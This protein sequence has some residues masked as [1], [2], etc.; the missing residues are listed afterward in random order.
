MRAAEWINF[1]FFLFLFVLAWQRPLAPDRRIKITA[2]GV[3][4][5]GLVSGV[6]FLDRFLSP[7]PASVIRDWLPA[8]LFLVAYW[9]AGLFFTTPS[10]KLQ[11]RLIR[12]DRKVLGPLKEY[13]AVASVRPW[14]ASYFELAY[15]LC[16]SLVPFGIGALYIARMGRYADEFWTIVLPS[17]YL[18]YT[19]LPFAQTLPPRT[20]TTGEE[21]ILPPTKV[22]ELNLWILHHGSIQ[23]NTFPSAHVATAFS[24]SLALL[25]LLPQAGIAFLWISVSI[26]IGAVLGR[27]HYAADVLI[28]AA[29]AIAIFLILTIWL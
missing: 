26:A 15:L 2:V 14:I 28:G 29:V 4:A 8:P 10:E 12:V 3:A 20:L 23:V 5:I 13:L 7:L 16:Y 9:T 21:S 6:Q 24:V 11:N 1:G 19:A 27:Y 17:A 25:H 22:R 18:C